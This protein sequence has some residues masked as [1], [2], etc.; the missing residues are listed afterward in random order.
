MIRPAKEIA[1]I[2]NR[3]G[4]SMYILRDIIVRRVIKHMTINKNPVTR[5]NLGLFIR[6]KPALHIVIILYLDLNRILHTYIHSKRT[7]RSEST[8]R[9]RIN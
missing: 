1:Y 2:I 5:R 8:S 4:I 3:N 9:W 7:S 6:I